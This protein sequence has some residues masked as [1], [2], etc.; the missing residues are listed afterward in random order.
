MIPQSPVYP[1]GKELPLPANVEGEATQAAIEASDGASEAMAT[2]MRVKTFDI[3][4]YCQEDLLL[5]VN[6]VSNPVISLHDIS[7]ERVLCFAHFFRAYEFDHSRE[8]FSV[9]TTA[10]AA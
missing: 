6:Q 8:I 5:G 3:A 9:I 4:H 2:A 10:T 7:D 1:S